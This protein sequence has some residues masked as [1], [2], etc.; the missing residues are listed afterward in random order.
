MREKLLQQ[1]LQK[2]MEFPAMLLLCH[3]VGMSKEA[4]A[5]RNP[6]FFH[7]SETWQSKHMY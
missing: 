3:S 7:N 4:A 6:Y 2:L 5:A 1:I